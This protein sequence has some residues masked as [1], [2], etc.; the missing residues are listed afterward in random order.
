MKKLNEIL[1]TITEGVEEIRR[2]MA[3]YNHLTTDI[4]Y[5]PVAGL[6]EHTVVAIIEVIRTE[7]D[8]SL[9]LYDVAITQEPCEEPQIMTFGFDPCKPEDDS[10]ADIEETE[11]GNGT[12]ENVTDDTDD[13]FCPDQV[14]AYSVEEITKMEI[15]NDFFAKMT[16]VMRYGI[17]CC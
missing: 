9:F 13:E 12:A 2:A 10:E 6:S 5:L 8:F 16:N 4:K 1:D 17:N 15:L 7:D 14:S 11:V 3:I